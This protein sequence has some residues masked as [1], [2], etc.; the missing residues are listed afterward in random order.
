MNHSVV[1]QAAF[2]VYTDDD[3][4]ASER[5]LKSLCGIPDVSLRQAPTGNL[6]VQVS[7]ELAE[8]SGPM[9]GLEVPL[10][11][12]R[13]DTVLTGAP[14]EES[15]FVTVISAGG[16]PAFVRFQKSGIPIFFCASSHMIDIDQAVG[17]GFYDVKEHFCSVV[18]L[19]MFVKLIFPD[20]A[21]RPQELGACLIIDDPLLRK[22]YGSCDFGVLRNLMQQYG[23]TTNVAFIPWNWRR[24][25]PHRRRIFQKRVRAILRLHSRLRP[26]RSRVWR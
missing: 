12:R 10:Q 7:R 9:T 1:R 4:D 20:I 19:V 8:V 18:P 15:E 21:W 3:L 22:R 13:E 24:T 16:D 23:F 25:S 6:L 2:Y 26:H 11:L 14:G 17:P 5:G